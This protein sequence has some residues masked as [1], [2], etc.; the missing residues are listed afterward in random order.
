[1]RTKQQ[2]KTR[3]GLLPAYLRG[4]GLSP[5]AALLKMMASGVKVG[6]ETYMIGP[7]HP[8]E[9]RRTRDLP[10]PKMKVRLLHAILCLRAAWMVTRDDRIEAC[11]Y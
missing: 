8:S 11:G 5:D 10:N 6:R 4:G 9:L 3:A 7:G 2:S 1:M